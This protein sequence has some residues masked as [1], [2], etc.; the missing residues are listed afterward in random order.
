MTPTQTTDCQTAATRRL[1]ILTGDAAAMLQM[2]SMRRHGMP[3]CNVCRTPDPEATFVP[4]YGMVMCPACRF[5]RTPA[6]EARQ[7]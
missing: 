6:P 7:P 1:P 5:G 3:A 4:A 2:L